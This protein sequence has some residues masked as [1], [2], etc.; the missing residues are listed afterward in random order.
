MKGR[1]QPAHLFYRDNMPIYVYKCKKCGYEFEE[2]RS[3]TDGDRATC[4][5]CG[6]EATR[7]LAGSVGIIFKGKGFYSTDYKG[8][9]S[10]ASSNVK[11]KR[12]KK[13]EEKS[14]DSKNKN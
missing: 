6:G 9:T 10:S 4:P 14:P 11:N 2:L 8:K 13:K 1:V 3:M 5:K 7:I 12:E